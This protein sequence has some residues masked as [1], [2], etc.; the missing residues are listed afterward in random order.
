MMVMQN[1][2][3]LIVLAVVLSATTIGDGDDAV[4][5]SDSPPVS[6][7]NDIVPIFS[8]YGCNAGS[9]HGAARGKDGFRLSLF[10]FDPAGDYRT[11]V[12]EFPGRRV[13]LAIPSE[14]LLLAKATGAVPHTGGK[15]FDESSEHYQK[16]LRWISDSPEFDGATATKV[17]AVSMTPREIVMQGHQAK[18]QLDVTASYADDSERNVT[19]L[20]TFSSGNSNVVTVSNEGELTGIARGEAFVMAR[21][22]AHT[23]GCNVIVHSND[24]T[25]V[26]P[27]GMKETNYI[28]VTIH[29]KLKK[30]HLVPASVCSDEEFLRRVSIDLTG[31]LPTREDLA[32]FVG[33][34]DA[35]KRSKMIDRML[36]TGDYERLW[37]M[38]WFELLKVS[39][40]NRVSNK[41]I[42]KFAQWLKL[43]IRQEVPIKHWLKTM[44]TARGSEFENP[45]VTFFHDLPDQK[46]V[47]EDVAQ[48]F[49]GMRIQCAQCHNHPFDRW[50]MDDYYGFVAFFDDVRRKR[51][52]DPR[53]RIVYSVN[54]KT[55]HPVTGQTVAPRFLGGD[56]PDLEA[57]DHRQAL[58]DWILSKDNPYFAANLANRTWDHFFGI[59]VVN[60]VD[61]VRVSNPP[62][63][64]ALLDQLAQ[65]MIETDYDFKALA[66]DICNSQAYQRSTRGNENEID[67]ENN[68]AKARLRRIRAEVLLDVISQVTETEDDFE[69]LSPGASATEIPDGKT[70]SHFLK[71]FGQSTRQ[72]VCSCEVNTDPN[73]SQALHLINGDTVH[74]KISKGRVVDRM[75]KSGMSNDEIIDDLYLRCLSRKP[76]EHERHRLAPELDSSKNR[77]K[78]LQDIFWALLNSREFLFNH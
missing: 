60:E 68:F 54:G 29:Q 37:T 13:N 7:V 31:R 47:A 39:T 53:D 62:V 55:T 34:Q 78:S 14:S 10:G 72:T 18:A 27:D 11:V 69:G 5:V 63:N 59:G 64:Q 70:T 24:E 66:R 15:L 50:T 40:T 58:A 22:G 42:W 51:G 57:T 74:H 12:R 8:R 61:D 41:S 9:C 3:R 6:F 75:L 19:R 33:D 44:L 76:T 36:M 65:R 38:K 28:D 46:Q 52:N 17:S 16:L 23:V 4:P 49:L 26:W 32:S 77:T 35:D 67:A 2:H 73:L 20:A 43:N 21:F 45:P 25:F 1:L 56:S 71:T 48:V 30:L